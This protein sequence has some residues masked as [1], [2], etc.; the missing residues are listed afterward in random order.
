LPRFFIADF[1]CFC[2]SFNL[3]NLCYNIV[4]LAVLFHTFEGALFMLW[5]TFWA[6]VLG[7]TLSAALQ[8]FVRRESMIQYFGQANLRS[9]GVA[10]LLGAVSSSC[11]YAAAAAAKS[12]FQK[13]A[14][15]I[16]TLA[17][18]F[19]ATNLVLELGCV[20]WILLGWH[21]VL[22]E[23]VGAFF[24]IAIMWI[25]TALTLPR[26][27]IK[28]ARE[29]AAGEKE[30]GSCCH[31]HQGGHTHHEHSAHDSHES[32]HEIAPARRIADAFFMDVSMMWKEILIGF[33]IAGLLMAVVPSEGWRALFL[34]HG[35]WPLRLVEN[36]CVGV[37][38]AMV[39]FVCSI[40]NLPLAALLW[41]QGISFGGVISFIYADLVIVPLLLIYR[42][43]YGTRMALYITA[44]LTAS[45]ILAGI[46][47]DVLFTVLGLVPQ[48]ARPPS[49][50]QQAVFQ[51]NYT[52]WLDLLALTA[53]LVLAW[54]QFS[55]KATAG[56]SSDEAA[57]PA[58]SKS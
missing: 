47:V 31:S 58:L 52:S 3:A 54:L 5:E 51:W 24:L 19:A 4:V 2:P 8:A 34:T 17:F 45:M 57:S 49:P 14:H 26:S 43:Y 11:S 22:A 55:P 36:A 37:L 44:I 7:F 48:G 50:M 38:I 33:L 10:T 12:A 6:L 9:V 29:R 18:M 1:S 15:L 35:G 40:G 27:W 56:E 16:P 23:V 42:K 32:T 13:G 30:D 21:F 46:A 39:S 25:L 20:L 53:L 28:Q 41:S